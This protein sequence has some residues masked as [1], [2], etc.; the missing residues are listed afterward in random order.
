MDVNQ[1]YSLG[2]KIKRSDRTEPNRLECQNRKKK[3]RPNF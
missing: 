3:I 1:I 2:L